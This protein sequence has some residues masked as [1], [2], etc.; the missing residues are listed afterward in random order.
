MSGIDVTRFKFF[1]G[2]SL[3][4]VTF[5]TYSGDISSLYINSSSLDGTS[6]LASVDEDVKGSAL[7]G[8]F[9]L[10][11]TGGFASGFPLDDDGMF[12]WKGGEDNNGSRRSESLAWNADADDVRMA[13]EDLL[14]E[15][16]SQG[17]VDKRRVLE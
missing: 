3:W 8:H 11:S 17:D 10:Y 5:P 12:L 6:V 16:A 13:V 14:P 1:S 4:T 7:G 2:G 9:R 15:S